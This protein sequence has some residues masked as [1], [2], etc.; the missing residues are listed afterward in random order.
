VCRATPL[1][2][3]ACRQQQDSGPTILRLVDDAVHPKFF[4]GSFLKLNNKIVSFE[5]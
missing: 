5:P 4:V 1:P 3:R 2:L